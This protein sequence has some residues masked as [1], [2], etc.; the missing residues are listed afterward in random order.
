MYSDKNLNFYVIKIY[1]KKLHCVSLASSGVISITTH[2]LLVLLM[3][4]QLFFYMKLEFTVAKGASLTRVFEV[5]TVCRF[6]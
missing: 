1:S 4:V 5:K 3:E 6:L 2:S